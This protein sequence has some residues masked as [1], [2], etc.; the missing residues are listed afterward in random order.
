MRKTTLPKSIGY[1]ATQHP[2]SNFLTDEQDIE[3]GKYQVIL[4]SPELALSTKNRLRPL[5]REPSFT[6][7]VAAFIVDEAHCITQWGHSFRPEYA[8]LGMLR[9]YGTPVL[10]LSATLSPDMLAQIH[11]TMIIE[12]D[13]S[14]HLNLGNDRPN[15]CWEVCRMNGSETDFASLK[16]LLPEDLE[17]TTKFPK[18]MVFFDE[19]DIAMKAR[20]WFAQQI[21]EHLCYRLKEYF[22]PRPPFG[23]D[24]DF[25]AFRDG[26][27]DILFTTEA[28]GMVCGIALFLADATC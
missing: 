26:T 21:P 9:A 4:T 6:K 18:T 15:I 5:L 23:K 24:L 10:A 16:F 3:K 12:S 7:R 25:A 13:R 19:I 17:N 22:A 14:F 8:E 11:K 1:V 28:A 2:S 27:V 20:R